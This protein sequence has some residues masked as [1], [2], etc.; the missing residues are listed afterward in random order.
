[1]SSSMEKCCLL[2]TDSGSARTSWK[3]MT[4]M[5]FL[6]STICL[7]AQQLLCSWSCRRSCCNL[8]TPSVQLWWMMIR[9]GGGNKLKSK[10]WE[11]KEKKAAAVLL[12]LGASQQR[13]RPTEKRNRTPFD[14]E[15]SFGETFI[16]NSLVKN[17]VLF[18]TL[19]LLGWEV[20]IIVPWRRKKRRKKA[21]WWNVLCCIWVLLSKSFGNPTKS[22]SFLM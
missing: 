5:S 15:T 12:W 17:I 9:E 20:V 2:S 14:E 22:S 6:S 16:E 19:Y 21:R 3:I 8:L 1:M 10:S 13:S 4:E 7:S 11:D 18:G